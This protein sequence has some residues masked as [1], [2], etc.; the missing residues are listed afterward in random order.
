MPRHVDPIILFRPTRQEKV[1]GGFG[2][3]RVP[4]HAVRQRRRRRGRGAPTRWW[5]WWCWWAWWRGQARE[6][7]APAPVPSTWHTGWAHRRIH[8]MRGARLLIT[9]ACA[10]LAVGHRSA[11]TDAAR[12]RRMGRRA[13]RTR[14]CQRRHGQRRQDDVRWCWWAARTS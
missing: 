12:A 5:W 14:W 9:Y 3:V 13:R 7:D 8:E 11:P 2:F 4:D 10:P 6:N 1:V